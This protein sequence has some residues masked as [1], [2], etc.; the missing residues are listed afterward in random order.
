[1]PSTFNIKDFE[2]V[3]DDSGRPK[4]WKG[5]FSSVF[6]LKHRETN[7]LYAMKNMFISQMNTTDKRRCMLEVDTLASLRECP[8]VAQIIAANCSPSSD[9]I[10]ILMPYYNGG[11]LD[12]VIQTRSDL[13]S[14]NVIFSILYQLTRALAFLHSHH[15]AHRDC[16][17]ANVLLHHP[18]KNDKVSMEHTANQSVV[19]TVL[20]AAPEVLSGLPYSYSADIFSL[21]CVLYE[22]VTR[23][24]HPFQGSNSYEVKAAIINGR[25][26]IPESTFSDLIQSMLQSNPS[27][28][29]SSE[30]LLTLLSKRNLNRIMSPMMTSHSELSAA[31][32][33]SLFVCESFPSGSNVVLA[34]LCKQL[35]H[36][37]NPSVIVDNF[38][39]TLGSCLNLDENLLDNVESWDN[40][41]GV[42]VKKLVSL[43][44]D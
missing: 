44:P 3:T 9:A 7:R 16:K 28:R 31:F 34:R 4:H 40:W 1:M 41:S 22:L 18:I 10:D 19:G 27:S 14:D 43:F 20:Y 8:Y 37:V 5:A 39:P 26:A 2:F 12:K 25:Y 42:F 17:S 30:E 23:G 33:L 24:R 36:E 35:F 11:A 15:I 6:L 21:G 13:L 32:A 29:P 38:S